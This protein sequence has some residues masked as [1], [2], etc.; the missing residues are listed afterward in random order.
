MGLLNETLPNLSLASPGLDRHAERR[1]EPGLVAELLADTATRVLV[2]RGDKV[3]V[4]ITAGPE[5]LLSSAP[6]TAAAATA[7]G[8][9][10]LALRP[11]QESDS[12]AL[13]LYLGQEGDGPAYLAV[14]EPAATEVEGAVEDAD[15]QWRSLRQ[16]GA[17][18]SDRDATVFAT[19]L[20]LANWHATHT[21]CPRCGAPTDPVQ[22]GWL[23][24]CDRDGSEHYPRTDVAVIMSVI[25][26]Q[27]RLLLARGAGWGVG[28]FS[29]LAG[30][31]EPGES[32]AA[33]V[34]REVHEEVGLDVHDV[35]YLGDQPWPF[36]N[37][38]MVGFT[39]R[40]GGGDL[41]LQ[42]S[43]IAEARWFTREEYREILAAGQVSTSTRLSIS[44]RIIERWL[45]HDLDD[46]TPA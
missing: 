10:A 26:D 11:P 40:A 23:R 15:E 2:V 42:E 27:D 44:R 13:V 43:E 14:V 4:V 22:G 30:F 34:A 1:S 7:H 38:I 18:L 9:T 45:G 8:P 20:A 29:V 36:P 41:R 33:A 46:V 28:R 37:S 6:A 25:D 21:H 16:I 32:L 17:D 5:V 3:P 12:S 19:A 24:R 35:E 39:A 31:L